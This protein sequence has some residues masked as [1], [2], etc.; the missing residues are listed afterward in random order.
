[1]VFFLGELEISKFS[2]VFS[3]DRL[4]AMLLRREFVFKLEFIEFLIWML[5]DLA[6]FLSRLEIING[7]LVYTY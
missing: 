1:M 6:W 7:F 4:T 5:E 2:K 3:S